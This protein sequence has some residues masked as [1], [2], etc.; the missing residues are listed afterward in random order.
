MEQDNSEDPIQIS[1]DMLVSEDENDAKTDFEKGMSYC[2]KLTIFLITINIIVFIWQIISGTL[3]SQAAIIS[4]GALYRESVFK[5]EIW[6]LVTAAFLHGGAGHLVGNCIVL[7][8]V[9]MACEHAFHMKRTAVIYFTACLCGSL[10]SVALQPG[11]S[12]GSSGAV[13]GIMGSVIVFLYKYQNYFYVRDKRIGFILA[14]WT[15]FQIAGGLTNPMIDNF[16][17][18]GGFT[19]GALAAYFLNPALLSNIREKQDM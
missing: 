5:G 19:G 1:E 8:I 15:L 17:H 18:I 6:R 13:F 12:V 7:Y 10:L 9:G 4:A 11:P 2:P 16:A 14:I 3:E